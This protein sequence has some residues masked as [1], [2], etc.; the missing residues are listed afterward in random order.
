MLTRS[1]G[2]N[3]WQQHARSHPWIGE[4][5]RSYNEHPICPKCEKIALRHIGWT[6]N[7]TAR[8]PACGWTGR[9]PVLLR[10]YTRDKLWR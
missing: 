10:E 4:D 5:K 7:R 2:I 8:C 1:M 3:D 9:A 6:E